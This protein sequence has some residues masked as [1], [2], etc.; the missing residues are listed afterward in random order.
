VV[1]P[2]A[3]GETQLRGLGADGHLHRREIFLAEHPR[4]GIQPVHQIGG[5]LER[6]HWHHAGKVTGD[7]MRVEAEVRTGG[8]RRRHRL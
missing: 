1:A 8:R 7:R 4:G 3:R 5:G 6:Q 2:G